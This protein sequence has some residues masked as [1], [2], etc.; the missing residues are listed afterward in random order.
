MFV[1]PSQGLKLT[2]PITFAPVPPGLLGLVGPVLLPHQSM[3]A[4][5]G[6]LDWLLCTPTVSPA[7]LSFVAVSVEVSLEP[8]PTRIPV[9]ELPI[10][11]AV[12]VAEPAC[13]TE[14]PT[15]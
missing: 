14:T 15:L 4:V 13:S 12:I 8:E 1:S 10:V 6:P 9:V 3:V 7:K 11:L 5:S 2:L